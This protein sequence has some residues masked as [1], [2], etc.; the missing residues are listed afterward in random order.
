MLFLAF[1]WCI[2][3]IR[4]RRRCGIGGYSRG[5]CPLSLQS[6]WSPSSWCSR[7]RILSKVHSASPLCSGPFPCR[8]SSLASCLRPAENCFQTSRI[9][10]SRWQLLP[11]S[12]SRSP[13]EVWDLNILTLGWRDPPAL[14]W[15]DPWRAEFIIY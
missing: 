6:S 9:W 8:R 11:S 5:D 4:N 10:A 15:T 14:L 2:S 7:P 13:N 3:Q 12:T 1:S